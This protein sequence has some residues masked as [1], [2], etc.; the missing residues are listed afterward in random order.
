M[1]YGATLC[2]VGAPCG[3]SSNQSERSV[4]WW[5]AERTALGRRRW[6]SSL[7]AS[8]CGLQRRFL[9]MVERRFQDGAAFALE[10]FKYFV[11][12]DLANQDEQ[13]CGA[14]LDCGSGILH[15]FVVDADIR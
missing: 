6:N 13:R 9:C 1:H 8:K 7:D 12:G 11:G 2:C 4:L 3:I 5:A 15:K 10:P 14:G